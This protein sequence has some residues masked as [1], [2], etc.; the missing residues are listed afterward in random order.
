MTTSTTCGAILSKDEILKA[1][2]SGDISIDP[3]DKSRVNCASVD[4][5]L[6]NEFRFF[7]QTNNVIP[8]NEDANYKDFSE[9]VTVTD[10]E[11][12]VLQPGQ[13]CLGITKETIRLAPSICGILEGRSRFARFGMAIHIT[14]G[15]MNPGI[16]NRQV[17]EIF[18]ASPNALLLKPGTAV[19]QFVFLR[20]HGEGQYN[21]K[22][23]AQEL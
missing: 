22:F 7:P 20:M 15:F 14:A 3:F 10:E 21:G 12:F 5:C 8:M 1:I 18:N 11:G 6:G 19:C 2:D 13:L 17:L 16:Q 23:N 4:L 9:K